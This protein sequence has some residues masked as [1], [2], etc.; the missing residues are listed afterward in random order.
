MGNRAKL[1]VAIGS[2]ALLLAG[3]ATA[4]ASG[5]AFSRLSTR[6]KSDTAN[7]SGDTVGAKAKC[8]RGTRRVSGGFASNQDRTSGPV[9]FA[10]KAAHGRKWKAAG[11]VFEPSFGENYKV[12]TIADCAHRAPHTSTAKSSTT[13]SAADGK[14]SVTAICPHGTR[15]ISG[16]FAT[17]YNGAGP[18]GNLVYESR[19]VKQRRW[20]TSATHTFGG[21]DTKLTSFAYCGHSPRLESASDT[22]PVDDSNPSSE[23]TAHCPSHTRAVSG[24]FTSTLSPE[25]GGFA[26]ALPGKSHLAELARAAGGSG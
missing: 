13:I 9:M 24:G 1:A 19:R 22:V 11:N 2:A 26:S 10:S 14:G 16:G 4:L 20:K 5:G 17:S 21:P 6:T 7:N 3:T 8:P 15:A 25:G 12:T 18:E 23:A